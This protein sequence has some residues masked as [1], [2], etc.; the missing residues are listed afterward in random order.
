MHAAGRLQNELK[1]PVGNL[2]AEARYPSQAGARTLALATSCMQ[3]LPFFASDCVSSDATD[4]IPPRMCHY[5]AQ[6]RLLSRLI[7]AEA[8]P[9]ELALPILRSVRLTGL[10]A[11][12][13]FV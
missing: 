5:S 10:S 6:F 11:F 9:D 2:F 3:S 7:R 1:N 8:V 12:H 13:R 4:E